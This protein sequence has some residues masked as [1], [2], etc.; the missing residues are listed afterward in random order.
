MK[1]LIQKAIKIWTDNTCL[2]FKE[3]GAGANKIRFY[4]G[5]GCWSYI[6]KIYYWESQD[7]S[8]GDGCEH[9]RN[10]SSKVGT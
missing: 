3:N 9:V 2:T 8:I 1:T 10:T 4:K 6:G 7:V 5:T